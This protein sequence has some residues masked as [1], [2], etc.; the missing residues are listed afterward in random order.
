VADV[1]PYR[2]IRPETG[3]G[4]ELPGDVRQLGDLRRLVPRPDAVTECA[5][6]AGGRLSPAP[7]RGASRSLVGCLTARRRS[8]SVGAGVAAARR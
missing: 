4:A 6:G 5:S 7:R 1:T 2:R 8:A 3:S